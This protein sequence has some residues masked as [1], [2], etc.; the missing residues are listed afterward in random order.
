MAA[1]RSGVSALLACAVVA[2]GATLVGQQ[3]PSQPAPAASGQQPAAEPSQ[4]PTFRGGIN[5]VR[6]DVI[7]SARDGSVISD[8]QAGDFDVTEDGKPQKIETFKF[9][10]LDGGLMQTPGGPPPWQI[11]T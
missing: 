11:R 3:Q 2:A 9:V 6:V 8:L 1:F 10:E 7:A 4:Q 5:F